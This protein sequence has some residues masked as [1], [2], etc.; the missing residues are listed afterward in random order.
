MKVLQHVLRIAIAFA[1][2]AC[3]YG[4]ASAQEALGPFMPHEGGSIT[5]AW[6]NAYG[7]DAESWIRFSKVGPDQFDINY[8][9]SRGTVAA[10]RI[11]VSDRM[12]ARTLVLGYSPKMP[13]IMENTTTLGT[14]A[15]VLEEL[16]TTGQASSSLVYNAALATMTGTFILAEKS[17][18]LSMDVDGNLIQVPVVHA[19]GNFQ[20]GRTKASGDFWFLDNRNNP[21]LIQYSVQFTGEKTP[22]TERFVR[23]TPG[24]SERGALEQTLA[25]RKDY[26]TYGIHFDFDK[27]SIRNDSVGL[28]SE[29]ATAL[30]SNPLWS[31]Q[32][33]GHTDS[34]GDSG[35]NE[36][37]SRRRADS[38]KAALVKRGVDAA[39]LT[40]VGAGASAPVTTNKTLQGRALNRRVVLARTDR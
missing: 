14:S 11:R 12:T 33:T 18:K 28:I 15:A 36:K 19:T 38:V 30:N 8:S 1:T 20:D 40:T 13:L 23:V 17:G 26:T 27:A 10:R 24:A 3:A 6:A 22:R 25:A 4:L 39:R 37:L 9:S 16:R 7:P 32:I 5:T 21:L 31:L 34:I 2:F 29:I 35:Y